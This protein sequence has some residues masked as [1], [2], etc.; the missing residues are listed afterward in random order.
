MK[1]ATGYAL[2][3][4]AVA[5]GLGRVFNQLRTFFVLVGLGALVVGGVDLTTA[6]EASLA[7]FRSRTVGIVFQ[8]FHLLRSMTA[9][10]NVRLPLELRDGRLHPA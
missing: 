9:L 8:H 1:T 4:A 6:D 5:A 2:P 10:E 7:E 3:G